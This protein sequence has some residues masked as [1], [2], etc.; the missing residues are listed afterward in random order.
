MQRVDKVPPES[1]VTAAKALGEHGLAMTRPLLRSFQTASTA[2]K[3]PFR[4]GTS[5]AHRV[6]LFIGTAGNRQDLVPGHAYS[7]YKS[8]WNP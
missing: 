7:S 3:T 2:G 8:D 6:D 1:S 4:Q 5:L